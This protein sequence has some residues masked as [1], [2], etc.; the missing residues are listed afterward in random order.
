MTIGEWRELD[1]P[2]E[3]AIF[4]KE[5]ELEHDKKTPKFAPTKYHYGQYN[6][7]FLQRKLDLRAHVPDGTYSV[8]YPSMNKD[9]QTDGI[10][11]KNGE[12][13]PE[14]TATAIGKMM[15]EHFYGIKLSMKDKIDHR[16]IERM[17]YDAKSGM[18]I[19]D[20]GS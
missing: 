19:L 18:F 10:V 3:W 14:P 1:L 13:V 20:V 4:D 5:H 12:F 2:M 15:R 6:K 17:D 11:V 7:W 8:R 9:M 16:Y